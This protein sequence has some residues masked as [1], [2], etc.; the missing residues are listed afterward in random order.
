MIQK[1]LEE[2]NDR[3]NDFTDKFQ[4][5]E[6]YN[7]LI[8]EHR[9]KMP[10]KNKKKFKETQSLIINTRKKLEEGLENCEVQ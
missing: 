10:E 9:I 5:V 3:F 4:V 2:L 1:D 7:I 6:Q 8:D